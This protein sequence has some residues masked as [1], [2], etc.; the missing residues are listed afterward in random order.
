[1]T[2]RNNGA[3]WNF[4]F[5]L[6]TASSLDRDDPLS[7]PQPFRFDPRLFIEE[8]GKTTVTQL[9]DLRRTEAAAK[10]SAGDQLQLERRGNQVVVL[11]AAGRD[12]GRPGDDLYRC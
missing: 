8:S 7:E 10:L 12:H 11:D 1:M 9:T 3:F 5:G 6:I 4:C 2:L